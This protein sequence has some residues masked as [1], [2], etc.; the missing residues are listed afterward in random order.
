MNVTITTSRAGLQVEQDG[1]ALALS[2]GGDTII[3]ERLGAGDQGRYLRLVATADGCEISGDRF[4]QVDL[5]YQRTADGWIAS[6][7]LDRLP[8]AA[9]G[10]AMDQ[11]ALAHAF[12]VYGNRPPKRHTVYD[13]VR[14][15]GVGEILRL[16]TEAAD[17]RDAVFEPRTNGT[18]T[19]ADL[20]RYADALLEAIRLRASEQGNIVY[21]SSGWDSTSILGS[22]VHL[23]GPKKVHAIVGRMQYSERSGVINQFE[24]DRAKAIAE[25]YG[26]SLEIAEFDYRRTGPEQLDEVLPLFRQHQVASLVGLNHARLAKAARAS[27][28]GDTVFAGEISDGAHNL[29]F[30]Q[31]V[32]IFHPVLDFREYSDKMASYL[33]GPTFLSQLQSGAHDTD[34]IYQLLRGR[35]GAAL[36][37]EPAGTAGGRTRQLLA[38][39]FLRGG[40]MPLWSLRNSRA[41]T[42]DGRDAYTREMESAYLAGPAAAVDAGTLYAWYLRL[43]NSFHWQGSTVVTLPLTAEANGLRP[44]LPF[45][46]AA[47]QDFLSGMPEDWGRGLDFNRTK[48]PLKWML[49]NRIKYPY[50]LQSGPH[51]Y[52][53]DVDHSFSHAAELLYASSFTPL[54]RERLKTKEFAG[55]FSS[56][57]FD[58]AYLDGLADRYVAGETAGGAELT[59]LT[60]L[61]LLSMTGWY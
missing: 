24:I 16:G 29:G 48:Y 19:P 17:S 52:L 40:R 4:G 20:D 50:E 51:S 37:D 1:R 42:A 36:F 6:T 9:G 43:Y 3:G 33:F 7:S 26:V 45:W 57:W 23:F 32:T 28:A 13:G 53:Y 47:V 18:Y 54:F 59:D 15:L 55:R 14:R 11:G 31:Y 8:V 60:S 61:C 2:P 30:S 58:H 22:L 12:C 39:F 27:G 35:T 46:D 25:F 49:Q 5:Y 34:P 38:S 41:L 56:E 44:A 21:L 10:A